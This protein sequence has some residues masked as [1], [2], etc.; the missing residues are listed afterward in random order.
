MRARC[1][2]LTNLVGAT[3]ALL[4]NGGTASADCGTCVE[5][6]DASDIECR[7]EEA[8]SAKFGLVSCVATQRLVLQRCRT[9]FAN[10][11][12]A[13]R[14]GCGAGTERDACIADTKTARTN[15][16]DNAK[17][18]RND[19]KPDADG[20]LDRGLAFCSDRL[21]TCLAA[22]LQK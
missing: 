22:C 19:C 9:R 3:L 11:R 10:A 1:S 15:C 17:Q 7:A 18:R 14:Q 8:F 6:C 13:C 16:L 5:Q 21:G 4:S 20:Q 2:V 12:K